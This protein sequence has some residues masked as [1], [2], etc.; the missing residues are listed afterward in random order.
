[1]LDIKYLRE[2]FAVAEKALATRSGSVDLSSFKQ[3]DQQR[4]ELLNEVESL[5]A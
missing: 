1:M 3:L 4:R 2:N 5:K